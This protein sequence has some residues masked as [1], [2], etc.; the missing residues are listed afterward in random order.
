MVVHGG[1]DAALV[2]GLEGGGG[3]VDVLAGQLGEAAAV[4]A[5]DGVAGADVPLLDQGHVDVR[6]LRQGRVCLSRY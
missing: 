6:V 2:L 3:V 4:G 1:E 5:E